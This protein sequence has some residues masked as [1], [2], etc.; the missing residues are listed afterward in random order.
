MKT[1]RLKVKKESYGW[2]EAAAKEV[3]FVWNWCNSTSE[4][5]V[6]TYVGP[7]KW[8]SGFDLCS[9]SA[10]SSKL[11]EK[12]G[13][14]TVQ[15]VCTQYA[16]KRK[17]ANKVKLSWRSSCGARR[18]LGWVPFKSAGL[19]RKGKSLRFCGK[20]F[21]VFE[22]DRLDCI[23]WGD[24]QFSQDAVGDWWLSV[25][26]DIKKIVEPA[27]MESV[28]IDLGLKDTATTSDGD[29]LKSGSY[30]REYEMKISFAQRRAHKKRVKRLHRKVSRQRRDALH[31]FTTKI[32]SRYQKIVVGD[33]SSLKLA[34]TK[35]AKSTLDSGWGMLRQM[36]LYKGECAGRSVKVVNE[37]F[38]S[39]TCSCCG[40]LSG[41]KGV[42]GLRVRRWEC[43]DCGS[44]H[45][46]DINAARNILRRAEVLAS[47]YGN[48]TITS[49]ESKKGVKS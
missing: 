44:V 21:R 45:D 26:A 6:K 8:L 33:V 34:K 16:F 41:P 19:K 9:L 37:S 2:L 23:K 39:R 43:G 36:L 27:P 30:F 1:I 14:C 38:T 28:G 22:I 3:N 7:S 15:R 11:F 24:G 47:I 29:K 10:G 31:K 5:A 12:I 18:S 42:N 32:I 40:C 4:K 13:S 48:E 25:P 20:A 17:A 49:I 46:R 35:M